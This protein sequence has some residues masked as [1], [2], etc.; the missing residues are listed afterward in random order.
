MLDVL[1]AYYGYQGYFSAVDVAYTPTSG[2]ISTYELNLR[3]DIEGHIP[4]AGDAYEVPNGPHLVGHPVGATI[5]HYFEIRGYS[6]TG[7]STAYEDSV[8]GATS[9][10]WSSGVP[11][12]STLSS[13]TIV[14]IVG[15]RGYVW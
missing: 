4:I 7:G 5:F 11:A 14:N 13:S 10:S 3:N 9:I 6:N 8:H 15:G 1:N 12:Y 2:E